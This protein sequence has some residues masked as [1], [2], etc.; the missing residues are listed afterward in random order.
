MI[1]LAENRTRNIIVPY[2]PRPSQL[3][4]HRDSSK[5]RILSCGRRF[6]KTYMAAAE[7]WKQVQFGYE[8]GRPQVIWGVAPFHKVTKQLWKVLLSIIPKELLARAP[9]KTDRSIEFTNGSEIILH[10]TK[11]ED[12]LLGEGIDLLVMDE[13]SRVSEDAWLRVLFP[14]LGNTGGRVLFTSTPKGHNWYYDMFK[15]GLDPDDDE[16][17]CWQLPSSDNPLV[18]KEF[19]DMARQMMPARLYEQVFEG[20]FLEDADSVFVG[21]NDCIEGDLEEPSAGRIYVAG[22]DLARTHDYTVVTVLAA[23]Y[24]PPHVVYFERFH[25]GPQSDWEMQKQKISYV[26]RRYNGARC[27]IDA[28]GLGDP[29]VAELQRYGVRVTPIKFSSNI[30]KQQIIQSLMIAI[31]RKLLTFPEIP[32]MLEELRSYSYNITPSGNIQ[33][34][35][36]EGK[37][38][39]AVISLALAWHGSQ[40]VTR[41]R[42][43]SNV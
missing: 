17:K 18:T 19:L 34:S 12:T 43:M 42:D 9:N 38:D 25:H 30:K 14:S 32:I 36:P 35:A 4:I 21:I 40:S 8:A 26:A 24:D 16:V 10:S 41:I 2:V 20:K 22:I 33:Y 15:R 1:D 5:F 27:V 3:M 7:M 13:A 11:M 23:D 37:H 6:G 39:D 28:T 31:E 29:F